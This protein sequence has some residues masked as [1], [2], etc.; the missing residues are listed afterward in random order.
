MITQTS[1]LRVFDPT[2]MYWVIET[3]QQTIKQLEAETGRLP[4]A[5][6]AHTQPQQPEVLKTTQRNLTT[7]KSHEL[8][9]LLGNIHLS[10][11]NLMEEPNLSP[12]ILQSRLNSTLAEI[13]QIRNLMSWQETPMGLIAK[14]E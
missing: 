6:N 10:L 13:K 2:E 3:L 4:N 9:T 1:L 11:E 5:S 7:I 12:Q 14:G 8:Q